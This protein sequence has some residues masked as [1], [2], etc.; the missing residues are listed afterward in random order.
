MTPIA[1]RIARSSDAAEI[2]QIYASYVEQTA[3]TLDTVVP[4][5]AEFQT[6]ITNT[7]ERYP[8]I[9]AVQDNQIIGYA[10]TSAFNKRQAYDWSV[11]L[12]IYLRQDVRHQGLGSRFYSLLE[13]ISK[14]QNITNLN[15]CITYPRNEDDPYVTLASP[16]FHAKRG[17]TT[18]AHFHKCAYKFDRW[19]DMIWMEKAIL[20][21]NKQVVP[22]KEFAQ[23]ANQFFS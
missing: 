13:D 23:V 21:H 16:K 15:A 4:S 17:F 8:F 5:I 3:I 14:A 12:S 7:L 9:V 6:K 11:E 2:L 22:I 18:C 10:Y 19:Y 20:P 1:F